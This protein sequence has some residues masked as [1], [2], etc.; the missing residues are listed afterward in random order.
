MGDVV[1][2]NFAD[3]LISSRKNGPNSSSAIATSGANTARSMLQPDQCPKPAGSMT[4]H[5]LHRLGE[6]DNREISEWHLKVRPDK[7]KRQ[8]PFHVKPIAQQG[9]SS[10]KYDI[11]S[12]ERRQ[13]WY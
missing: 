1:D 8:D 3:A 11:I 6:S 2:Q 9:S 4:R 10:V 7:L 5:S 13:F 12:N